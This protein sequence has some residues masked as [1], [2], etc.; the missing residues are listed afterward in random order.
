MH[1][2]GKSVVRYGGDLA[3]HE[4]VHTPR[5]EH[6][7]REMVLRRR[8]DVFPHQIRQFFL[9]GHLPLGLVVVVEGPGPE[10][11]TGVG[12]PGA[13]LAIRVWVCAVLR[14]PVVG[15]EIE[16]AAERSGLGGRVAAV[17]FRS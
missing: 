16:H 7:V 10:L 2:M 9:R 15:E 5:E 6:A 11:T 12:D 8:P 13:I 17:K 4:P 1:R 3:R 14:H